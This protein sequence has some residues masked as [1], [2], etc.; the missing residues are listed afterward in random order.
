MRKY[1]EFPYIQGLSLENCILSTFCKI[2]GTQ[3]GLDVNIYIESIYAL[4]FVLQKCGIALQVRAKDK[5]LRGHVQ[6]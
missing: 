3:Y 6:V 5:S 4:Q 1:I 2:W